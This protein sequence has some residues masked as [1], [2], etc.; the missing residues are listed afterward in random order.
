[1]NEPYYYTLIRP[2]KIKKY[3]KKIANQK[4]HSNY[5]CE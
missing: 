3:Y 1:M 4:K 2:F 5:I